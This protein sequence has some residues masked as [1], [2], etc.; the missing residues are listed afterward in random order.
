MSGTSPAFDAIVISTA[1][2]QRSLE[3]LSASNV[4][5]SMDIPVDNRLHDPNSR[6]GWPVFLSEIIDVLHRLPGITPE[7]VSD[8]YCN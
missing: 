4:D 7:V 8:V 3:P 2:I 5:C 6:W 1:T